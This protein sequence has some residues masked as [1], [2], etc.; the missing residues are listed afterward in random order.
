M[1]SILTFQVQ[2]QAANKKIAIENKKKA[3]KNKKKANG[4][5]ILSETP[6]VVPPATNTDLNKNTKVKKINLNAEEAIEFT[7]LKE[8]FNIRIENQNNQMTE[9]NDNFVIANANLL[10]INTTLLKINSS[11]SSFYFILK[12]SYKT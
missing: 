10:M 12:L 9:I 6:I 5:Q 7:R 3:I 11:V 8:Q 2:K 1:F 4:I